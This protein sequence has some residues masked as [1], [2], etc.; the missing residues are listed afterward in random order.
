MSLRPIRSPAK[1]RR[2]IVY[3]LEWVPGENTRVGWTPMALRLIGV[4]DGVRYRSFITMAEFFEAM[5]I[6]SNSGAWIY[7]HAGGM[8]DIQYVFD[9]V[10][11]YANEYQ[12]EACFSGSSAIIVEIRKGKHTWTFVDSF[13]LIREGLRKIAAWVGME[14]GGAADSM[15]MFYAPLAELRDYNEQDCVILWKAIRIFEQIVLD[16]GGE[17]QKTIAS[18]ALNLFRRRFLTTTIPTSDSLNTLARES[19]VASRVEVFAANCES[20]NYYDINS[21]FPHSMLKPF[22]GRMIGRSKY[23]PDSGLYMA[24]VY[25]DVPM[26]YVPPLPYRHPKT[27]RVFFPVGKWEAWLTSVDIELLYECGGRILKTYDVLLFDPLDD[28]A[29]YASTIYEARRSTTDEALK[30]V[31]KYLLNSLYGKFAES[32]EKEKVLIFPDS[33]TCQHNPKHPNNSCLRMYAPG[34]WL[35]SETVPIAHAHVPISSTITAESRATLTRFMR[36]CERVYYVDTDA[37][38]T[39]SLFK[40]SDVLGGLK[41]EKR[42]V[43]DPALKGSPMERVGALFEGPKLYAYHAE[44]KGWTVR[45]KGFRKLS[46]SDYQSLVSAR[47]GADTSITVHRMARIKENL[48]GGNTTPREMEVV[49]RLR[50]IQGKRCASDNNTRPWHIGEIE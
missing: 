9:Y 2:V 29:G 15:D 36:Q 48:L 33:T 1:Q 37:F 16:F 10:V 24:K 34:I 44:T 13:W 8:A 47:H 5:L 45:A 49:K 35:L 28:L 50:P 26:Q 23:I 30:V 38:A 31:Y 22:P 19:Y 4:F 41:L 39:P 3:D 27:G 6:P 40:T 14:K 43:P 18:T 32:G 11:K 7:A 25:V 12:I 17:L 46:L 42:I 21:S 20:A